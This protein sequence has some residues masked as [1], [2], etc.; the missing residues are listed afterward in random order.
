M[1][2]NLAVLFWV[3]ILAL[4]CSVTA[5]AE[6]WEY[7]LLAVAASGER[8]DWYSADGVI[9]ASSFGLFG[10]F[11]TELREQQGAPATVVAPVPEEPFIAVLNILGYAGWELVTVQSAGPSASANY[12]FRRLLA[13]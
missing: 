9:E 8:V 1:K 7:G 12:Y 3:L 11:L 10:A 4:A 5:Q 13:E 2:R 6:R